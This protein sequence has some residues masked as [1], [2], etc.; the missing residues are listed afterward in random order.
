MPFGILP[1]L[2][3][4]KVV[5]FRASA[6]TGVG[7]RSPCG[8]KEPRGTTGATKDADC[9][10]SDLGS[11]VRNDSFLILYDVFNLRRPFQKQVCDGT[12]LGLDGDFQVATGVF[13]G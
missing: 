6:H 5:S 12:A 8:S 11:L 1:V 7:I 3:I 10:T 4:K 13:H 9:H 2:T